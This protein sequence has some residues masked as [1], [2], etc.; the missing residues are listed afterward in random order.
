VPIHW[1]TAPR[2]NT[3]SMRLKPSTTC[4]VTS[5]AM[6]EFSWNWTVGELLPSSQQGFIRIG[7]HVDL[8]TCRRRARLS[9]LC[10]SSEIHLFQPSIPRQSIRSCASRGT[11]TDTCLLQTRLVRSSMWT[12][13]VDAGP[14]IVGLSELKL[15][16]TY[17]T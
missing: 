7:P 2:A 1:T 15:H 17:V 9:G 14:I 6:C 16:P 8:E 13:A 11:P 10:A 4:S 5:H 12:P 3:G